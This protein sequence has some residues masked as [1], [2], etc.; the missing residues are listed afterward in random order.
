MATATIAP[1]P[2]INNPIVPRLKCCCCGERFE[3]RQFH[4]QDTGWG[5]GDCC[6]EIVKPHAG[7][8]LESTY[9]VPG[10]HYKLDPVVMVRTI[11]ASHHRTEWRITQ[12]LSDRWGE[13]NRSDAEH[14]PLEL[15]ESTPGLYD[16]LR[17]QM[18]DEDTFVV[19]KDAA[20]GILFEVE[21]CCV[22][23]EAGEIDPNDPWFLKLPG[24]YEQVTRLINGMKA[25]AGQFPSV[26]FAVP[27]PVHV[28]R[29]R[30]AA[31]AFVAD[32]LLSDE[33]R[34]AL[35]HALQVL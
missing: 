6:V 17:T 21:F 13:I 33:Q 2:D 26:Q 28:Y 8:E 32:G 31:W 23:S 1:H 4:D 35:G 18:F 29:E 27:E 11:E 24:Y 9:G 10:V 15:L 25:I 14:K 7:E 30:P 20:W 3:G 5:L 22:E 16:R 34:V 12:N 19:R